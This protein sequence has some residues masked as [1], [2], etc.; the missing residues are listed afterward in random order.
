MGSRDTIKWTRYVNGEMQNVEHLSSKWGRTEMYFG[1]LQMI[2]VVGF[3]FHCIY[4]FT[5]NAT[6]ATN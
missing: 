6:Q 2:C 4:L 5:V 1:L 3:I